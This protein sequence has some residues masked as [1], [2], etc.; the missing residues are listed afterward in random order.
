MPLS[1]RAFAQLLGA[2]AAAAAVPRL[3]LAAPR[4]APGNGI[5]R[6]SANENPYGPSP[7][8]NA[9][10]IYVCNPNN[11]TGSIT[12]TAALR[13]LIESADPSAMI[14]VDE[15]Y[16]HYASSAGY[17]SVIPLL[18]VH[19]NLVVARTFSKIYGMAGLRA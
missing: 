8:A 1:R 2:G 7:V 6:L 15:A 14:L 9:G 16:H 19:P 18:K 3:S 5:V 4:S 17:E 11:P 13:S 12:P 10:A